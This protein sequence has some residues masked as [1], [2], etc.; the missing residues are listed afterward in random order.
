[1]Y[2]YVRIVQYRWFT[3]FKECSYKGPCVTKQYLVYTV[4]RVFV[5]RSMRH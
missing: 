5:Q 1:M 3:R 4:Q 2:L